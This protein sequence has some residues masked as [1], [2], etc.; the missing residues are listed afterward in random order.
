MA[1]KMKNIHAYKSRFKNPAKISFALAMMT[2]SSAIYIITTRT[3]KFILFCNFISY[4][5]RGNKYK[6]TVKVSEGNS[7][8]PL[9]LDTS[10]YF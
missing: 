10:T 4:T 5:R 1:Y 3:D 9:T 2:K 6:P 8:H 7:G